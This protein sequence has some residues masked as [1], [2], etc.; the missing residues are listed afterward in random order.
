[1]L[2]IIGH[3]SSITFLY[4]FVWMVLAAF[5]QSFQELNS[6]QAKS[7]TDTAVQQMKLFRRTFYLV[8][9][10]AI[11]YILL[12]RDVSTWRY[13]VVMIA[14]ALTGAFCC[15]RSGQ[16]IWHEIS[17]ADWELRAGRRNAFVIT[18]LLVLVTAFERRV[19]GE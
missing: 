12:T 9:L 3:T 1:M 4:L 5:S 15:L 16:A 18:A 11:T 10:F 17:A 7:A 14:A 19:L 2:D 6:A 8:A 13:Q